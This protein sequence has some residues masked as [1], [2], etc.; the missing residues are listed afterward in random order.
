MKAQS[1]L[2]HDAKRILIEHVSGRQTFLGPACE[3]ILIK[4]IDPVP[5]PAIFIVVVGQNFS[6]L[7]K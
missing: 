4:T 2:L 1:N 7:T 6:H 3:Y 5:F